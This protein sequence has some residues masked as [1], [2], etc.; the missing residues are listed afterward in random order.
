MNCLRL[1]S[2]ILEGGPFD[3]ASSCMYCVFVSSLYLVRISLSVP[4]GPQI[5][6]GREVCLSTHYSLVCLRVLCIYS[7][8][9]ASEAEWLISRVHPAS[10]TP[11]QKHESSIAPAVFVNLKLTSSFVPCCWGAVMD[12][13]FHANMGLEQKGVVIGAACDEGR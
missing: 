13:A 4:T 5:R 1:L 2:S 11:L 7:A 10:G 9:I 6:Q 3:F 12:V 8:F